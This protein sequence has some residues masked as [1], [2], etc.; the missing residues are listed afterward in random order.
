M[1]ARAEIIPALQAIEVLVQSLVIPFIGDQLVLVVDDGES[2]DQMGAQ[3]RIHILWRVFPCSRSV[4]R[5]VG[6][7]ANHLGGR[8]C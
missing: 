1:A 4:L 2:I 8:S 7:V 5:P 3:E 6:E